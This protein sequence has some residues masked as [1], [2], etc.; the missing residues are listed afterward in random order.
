MLKHLR[1]ECRKGAKKQEKQGSVAQR[2][3]RKLKV[4]SD[5]IDRGEQN[6]TSYDSSGTGPSY[7]HKGELINIKLRTKQDGSIEHLNSS[8]ANKYF[9]SGG[10]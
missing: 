8:D 9:I 10:K 2:P 4:Q 7:R 6:R 5:Y 3:A 1:R